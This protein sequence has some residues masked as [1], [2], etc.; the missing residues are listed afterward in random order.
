MFPFEVFAADPGAGLPNLD[1]LGPVVSGVSAVLVGIV[2]AASLVWRRRQDRRDASEDR[3]AD[4]AIAVQPTVS[5]GWDEVRQA[6]KE[7]TSYYNLYRAFENL[8]YIAFGALRHLARKTRDAH[9][10]VEFEADI[11]EAL[12]T[13]PPDTTNVTR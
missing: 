13:T 1:W 3:S 7:A 4:A 11:I 8:Y 12:A 9:P 5:D 2:G 10:D 6:R